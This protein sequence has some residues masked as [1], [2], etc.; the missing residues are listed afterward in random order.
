MKQSSIITQNK[1]INET[2][3]ITTIL[4]D[5]KDIGNTMN[6]L[7][8]D[9]KDSILD[10]SY[11]SRSNILT[12]I[13]KKECILKITEYTDEKIINY[14]KEILNELKKINNYNPSL[15]PENENSIP[16]KRIINISSTQRNQLE[17][18]FKELSQYPY[19]FNCHLDKKTIILKTKESLDEAKIVGNNLILISE[20]GFLKTGRIIIEKYSKHQEFIEDN[21]KEIESINSDFKIEITP[22]YIVIKK[23]NNPFFLKYS[24][25]H[26]YLAIEESNYLTL[27]VLEKLDKE[28]LLN[29]VF[30]YPKK[31][32]IWIN[33]ILKEEKDEEERLIN[34]IK[35]KIETNKNIKDKTDQ[36]SFYEILDYQRKYN[37]SSS[38]CYEENNDPK[39]GNFCLYTSNTFPNNKNISLIYT[40]NNSNQY[41]III[42][43]DK[44]SNQYIYKANKKDDDR[45]LLFI[46]PYLKE[47]LENI[48]CR[49][50][51][52]GHDYYHLWKDEDLNK[53]KKEFINSIKDIYEIIKEKDNTNKD[54]FISL[55]TI[56][57]NLSK[58]KKDTNNDINPILEIRKKSINSN[59]EI[60]I[61]YIS[62]KILYNYETDFNKNETFGGSFTWNGDI[63]DFIDRYIFFPYD[64]KER[65]E[66]FSQI[67]F[68]KADLPHWLISE[69]KEE[70][71]EEKNKPKRLFNIFGG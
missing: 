52:L 19:Q 25:K 16:L 54:D 59:I 32:P 57:N 58:V 62:I 17:D 13:T 61:D 66:L 21:Y 38:I 18:F 2:D 4:A 14:S 53:Q 33:R 69:E 5:I 37:I 71:T 49:K 68:L 23:D 35:Q 46:R 30:F 29:K 45:F 48:Y 39:S 51:S 22:D 63:K 55:E 24:L 43:Y 15:P 44:E 56:F 70:K 7:Y 10:I 27:D 36:V 20:K 28:D 47:I 8:E 64:E 26:Q 11:E 42:T 31:C 65:N 67:Y 34:Q 6:Q 9:N 41:E 3:F 60:Y 1:K 12:I 50:S 40:D